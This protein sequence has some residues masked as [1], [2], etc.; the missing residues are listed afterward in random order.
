MLSSPYCWRTSLV[1]ALC[2]GLLAACGSTPGGLPS[3]AGFPGESRAPDT[4]AVQ[5]EE[6]SSTL[7]IQTESLDRELF[8]ATRAALQEGDWLAA[9]LALPKIEPVNSDSLNTPPDEFDASSAATL[10]WIDYYK[11][12]IDLLRGDTQSYKKAFTDL[13]SRP[14]PQDL[15][16]ELLTQE[17]YLAR[18]RHDSNA[19]LALSLQLLSLSDDGVTAN[20]ELGDTIWSAAQ[21]ITQQGAGPTRA[22]GTRQA[23]GWLDLAAANT[24]DNALDGAAALSAWEAQYPEH[25]AKA[26][27][28]A[29]REAALRDAQTSKLTL[30]LPL[31]GPLATAGEAV[32][33]GFIAAF[34]AAQDADLSIDVLDSRRFESIGDTYLEAQAKGAN[35][36]VGPLGKRQVQ[37]LLTRPQLTVPVLTLNRPEL[38]QS[39]NPGALLLSLAPEDEARQLASDAFAGGSRR[40]LVIRPEGEWGERMETALAEQWLQLGGHIPTTAIYGKPNTHSTA[41]RDALGL[42]DSAQRSAALR[43]LFSE[44]IETTGRRRADLDSIFLLS[45]TSDEARALKPLINYHYAGELPV[46][47]LSTADSGSG[48]TSLNRDLGG[49]RLLAMPWRLDEDTLPGADSKSNSAALHA[50]GADAYALARRWWRMRSTA[51]P[52][53]FGLTAELH[54]SPEGI[55]NRRLNMAEFDRGVL[56]PR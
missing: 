23:Q 56:R 43:A 52:I 22:G 4:T 13:K 28:S 20:P 11:A 32:S 36:I 42:G 47:S 38:M 7:E 44:R 54:T 26:H 35:L 17:L 1:W 24:L 33:R 30:I 6:Y 39:D 9:T 8:A 48:N 29:L 3:R 53:F 37:E 40:A 15:E 21:Q 31:S 25:L 46:Y 14:L 16:Q 51:A 45:K 27:A 18:G 5:V 49:L 10:L 12:R 2:A 19:Q 34:F 50:L 41:I 55:L